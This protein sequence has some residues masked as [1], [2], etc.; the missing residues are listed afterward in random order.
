M[1]NPSRRSKHVLGLLAAGEGSR[2]RSEGIPMSKGMVE[3]GGK[4]LIRRSIDRFVEAGI[5]RVCCIVNEESGDLQ[6]YLAETDFGVPVSVHTESTQSSLHSLVALSPMLKNAGAHFFLSMVDSICAP[7][8]L[9]RFVRRAARLLGDHEGALGVTSYVEDENPLFVDIDRD[10]GLI[11]SVGDLATQR[12]HV[13]GGLYCFPQA[14][15][16]VA[17][18][19]VDSGASRLRAFQSELVERGYKIHGIEFDKIIDVDHV[20]DIKAAASFL[21]EIKR[22]EVRNGE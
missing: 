20:S 14:S 4:P 6:R 10:E 3:V 7:A 13:T 1:M 19:L 16:D 15:L 18:E 8:E 11:T 12:T 17:R 2:L 22:S 9:R 21:E 5:E